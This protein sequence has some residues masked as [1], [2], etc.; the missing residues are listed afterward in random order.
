MH[1]HTGRSDG[2][3]SLD[4]VA[5]AAA[6]AGLAFVIITDHGD[7][8]ATPEPPGYRSGVLCIDAVE[9]STAGGHLVALDMPPAPYPLAGEPRDVVEDVHRLGGFAIAAH[10]DS[11]KAELRWR[12]WDVPIDGVETLNLDTGWRVWAQRAGIGDAGGEGP[13]S[14]P[15]QPSPWEARRHLAAALLDYPFR[16]VETIASL[17]TGDARL[18]PYRDLTRQRRVI[19]IAGADAHAKLEYH[20]E[21][22]AGR[23]SLPIPGYE[24]TFRAMSIRLTL[25]R[26]LTG[27]AAEDARLVMAAIRAGHLYTTVDAIA[28][29]A[30]IE[31]TA[32]N[33]SGTAAAGDALQPA[34]P[35][36]LRVR[37][38]APPGFTT[39]VWNGAE[40]I[41]AGRQ[42]QEFTVEAPAGPGAYWVSI[43]S[44]RG[45]QEG[46]TWVHT[47]PIYVRPDDP[48]PLQAEEPSLPPGEP[49]FDGSSS[50]GWRIESDPGSQGAVELA[51]LVDGPAL[52]FR[53]G[54]GA[55]AADSPFVG[56]VRDIPDGASPGDRLAFTIR[57]EQPMRVSV[58]LRGAPDGSVAGERWRRSV[59]V[60]PTPRGYVLPFDQFT[61]AGPARTP[62]A[63]SADV[64]SLLFVI[65]TVNTRPGASGRVWISNVTLTP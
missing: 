65:D 51:A 52:R 48:P 4:D 43:A 37:S 24:P 22:S 30:S 32:A 26:P 59:Y 56:L 23:P 57:A 41:S 36:T 55:G 7:A 61:P 31:F 40:A 13:V 33:G 53:Y 63:A 11:P 17:M 39:T 8:T 9:I 38:N 60:E 58:Q 35:V 14:G 42:E 47:N 54:L 15:D 16:P 10:P 21:A 44:N 3:G 64:R 34:G 1:I 27:D 12:D 20:G 62:R 25:E 49:L 45:R 50:A 6:E 5:A 19:S 28:T 18:P 2:K 29:P 46:R